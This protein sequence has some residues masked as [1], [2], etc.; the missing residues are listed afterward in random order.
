M[1]A[2]YLRQSG[3]WKANRAVTSEHYS[4]IVSVF[5]TTRTC[6]GDRL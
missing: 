5:E 4:R 2:F 6:V 3:G 1:P